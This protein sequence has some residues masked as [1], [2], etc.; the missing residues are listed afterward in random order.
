MPLIVPSHQDYSSASE[1]I[2]SWIKWLP[3]KIDWCIYG[4]FVTWKV[5]PGLSDIDIFLLSP[6]N[7]ILFPACISRVFSETKSDVER[8]WIP[9]QISY[10]TKWALLSPFASPDYFYLQE[11]KRWIELG[12]ASWDFSGKF[13]DHRKSNTDDIWMARYFLKK[14]S[15]L[16]TNVS[17]IV[18]I[19]GKLEQDITFDDQKELQKFWD[20]FKKMLSFCTLSVRILDWESVF[21]K[22]DNKIFERFRWKV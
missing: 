2:I 14:V 17:K 5:R 3:E 6:S 19:L 1:K 12:K 11:V 15:G 16:P 10:T 4:S 20:A 21:N 22:S 18:E 8:L 7:K 9:L 13:Q